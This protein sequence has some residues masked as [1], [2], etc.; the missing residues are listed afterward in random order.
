MGYAVHGLQ[1]GLDGNFQDREYG[2]LL[3]GGLNAI[4]QI[5]QGV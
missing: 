1:E 5:Y 2:S 4:R 3:E